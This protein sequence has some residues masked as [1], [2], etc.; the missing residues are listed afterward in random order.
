MAF[1]QISIHR[2]K[3]HHPVFAHISFCFLDFRAHAHGVFETTQ[4]VTCITLFDLG[5]EGD[6]MREDDGG[7]KKGVEDLR[8][9]GFQVFDTFD[10]VGGFGPFAESGGEGVVDGVREG[11]LPTSC[12]AL[13]TNIG[14]AVDDFCDVVSRH[15]IHAAWQIYGDADLLHLDPMLTRRMDQLR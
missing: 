3:I 2:I 8:G 7:E 13:F 9:T 6:V 4:P 14:F 10:N 1:H 12:F 15:E 5:F 11:Q